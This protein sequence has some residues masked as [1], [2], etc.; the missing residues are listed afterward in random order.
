MSAS[1]GSGPQMLRDVWAFAAVAILVISLRIPAKL[2]IGRFGWDDVLMAT[3][4][5]R[6]PLGS[7]DPMLVSYY[8]QLISR[9]PPVFVSSRVIHGHPGRQSWVWSSCSGRY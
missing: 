3:A 7:P 1:E 9:H 2:L 6:R 4:L 5:V 8:G